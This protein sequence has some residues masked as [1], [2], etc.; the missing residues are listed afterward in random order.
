MK[1]IVI[2]LIVLVLLAVL[3]VGA[4]VLYK[5]LGKKFEGNNLTEITSGEEKDE[6]VNTNE[7]DKPTADSE[8]ENSDKVTAPD[9]TVLNIEGKEVSLS[10]YRGKPVVINFW[11]TWCYYCKLEMPD[12]DKA[13]KNYPNVEFLMVNA[14]ETADTAKAY[15]EEEG[16][17]FSIFLDTD[18]EAVIKYGVTGLPATFFIDK[19]G[20]LIAKASGA[21]DYETLISGIDMINN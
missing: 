15:V 12:F 18:S 21:I 6:A 10:D 1:K 2:W 8:N 16:F 5:R 17:S 14:G 13:Y 7:S 19:N 9:F 20:K 3:I 4:S 11:A